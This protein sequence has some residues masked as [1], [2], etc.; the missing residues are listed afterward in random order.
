[1]RMGAEGLAVSED[2]WAG[3]WAAL[4]ASVVP[5]LKSHTP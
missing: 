1:V 3:L 2:D 4:P 5:T